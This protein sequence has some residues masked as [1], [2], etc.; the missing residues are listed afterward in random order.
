MDAL[1]I[2]VHNLC[3]IR[4]AEAYC[5]RVLA[6]LRSSRRF[7]GC[8]NDVNNL[9][10]VLVK[11]WA[12]DFKYVDF[13]N[14]NLNYLMLLTSRRAIYVAMQVMLEEKDPNR[15][16]IF[17]AKEYASEHSIWKDIAF[18][19]SRKLH[20]IH[21]LHALRLLPEGIPL[22]NCLQLLEASIRSMNEDRRKTTVSRNLYR[23][24]HVAAIS[25]RASVF[26]R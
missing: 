12:G 5:D 2:F 20:A 9:Y 24:R 18:L 17:L 19:L 16:G 26:Q 6:R 23:A 15:P 7:D 21:A 22:S 11:V 13:C 3:S 25:T 1:R 10:A 8:G 4:L 14:L